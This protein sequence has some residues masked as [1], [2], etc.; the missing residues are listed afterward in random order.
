MQPLSINAG[1]KT[2][3]FWLLF[4]FSLEYLHVLDFV[5]ALMYMVLIQAF[6]KVGTHGD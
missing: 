5:Q 4:L 6:F 1:V 2:L 3:E